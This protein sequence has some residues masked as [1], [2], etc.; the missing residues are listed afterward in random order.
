VNRRNA[1]VGLVVVSLAVGVGSIDAYHAARNWSSM[2][3][4]PAG[5]ELPAFAVERFG[6]GTF[7]QDDLRDKVTVVTFWATWCGVC[8]GELQDLDALSDRYAGRPVQFV[9]VNHEGGGVTPAQARP[10]VQ[11]YLEQGNLGLGAAIDTGAMS[12]TFRVGAIPHTVLFD[13]RGTVRHVHQGRVSAS[14]LEDQVD[15]LLAEH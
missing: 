11:R 14:T 15:A 5:T 7:S 12:R 2:G 3:P 8:R 4:L 9:A 13:P 1:L 6:G 10:M